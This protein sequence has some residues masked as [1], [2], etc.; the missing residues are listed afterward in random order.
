[1]FLHSKVK[2]LTDI[3]V[4]LP[5]RSQLASAFVTYMGSQPEDIRRKYLK[6]WSQLMTIEEF[7]FRKFVSTESQQLVWKGEG[8][9]SDVLSMENAMV[10]L[11]VSRLQ[12]QHSKCLFI[13]W[14]APLSGPSVIQDRKKSNLPSV[15]RRSLYV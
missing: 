6:K 13:S 2:E 7:D 11:K 15:P 12:Y 4:E 3:T 8:L 9:P 14:V 1:M 5:S 10:I